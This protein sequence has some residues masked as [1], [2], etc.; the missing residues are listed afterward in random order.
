M[1]ARTRIPLAIALGLAANAALLMVSGVLQ[2]ERALEAPPLFASAVSLT[3]VRPETAPEEER[4]REPDPPQQP[5]APDFAPELSRP[6]PGAPQLDLALP[7][8]TLAAPDL[9]FDATGLVFEASEL[10]TPPRVVTRLEPVYPYRARQRQ[11][12]GWVR[13]RFLVNPDGSLS[14]VSVLEAE[15]AGWFE[16]SVLRNVPTWTVD[17]GVIDGEPVAAWMATTVRFELGR[18]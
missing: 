18:R 11:V 3:T 2:H 4:V 10:D 17:P 14:D 16:E 9:R 7:I 12:E 5:P 1:T 15:P 8:P 13:V 6:A